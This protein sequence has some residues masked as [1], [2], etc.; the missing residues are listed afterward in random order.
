MYILIE[1]S[2]D[3]GGGAASSSNSSK[4]KSLAAMYRPPIELLFRG[5]FDAVSVLKTT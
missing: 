1:M 4:L 3:G 2:Q 5:S